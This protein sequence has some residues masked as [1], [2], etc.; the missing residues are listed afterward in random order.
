MKI[1][2]SGLI[3]AIVIPFQTDFSL[4][5]ETMRLYV[6]RISSC[7]IKGL[8][9]NTDAGEGHFLLPEERKK[10][11]VL[12]K[13]IVP[14]KVPVICGLG[15]A[16]TFQAVEMAKEF[17]DLGVDCFLVFPHPAFRG[18]G[19]NKDKVVINY[20]Q[21]I[22]RVGIPLII[23]QLQ[24]E[25]GGTHYG[26]ET[27]AELTKIDEV[28]AIKEASFDALEFKETVSFLNSLRKKIVILT[29]NDNFIPESF[30]LGA[31]GALIGFG[32][33]FTEIQ[34]EVI[35]LLQTKRYNQALALFDKISEICR[36]CF[37]APVRDYRARIKEVLV[38][39]GIFKTSLVR[40][41][42]LPLSKKEREEIRTLIQ[43]NN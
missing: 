41:P 39:Q 32:A 7:G 29:G 40:P 13:E 19:N 38:A 35:N 27:L 28:V 23:F 36:Y 6:Q 1:N 17:K 18:G 2:L 21:Q 4:D 42:L 3:P 11:V 33:I 30:L 20:H 12:A 34:V 14:D 24:E 9:V 43:L 8:A 22:A 15:G 10:I 25:L 16:T 37:R 26:L 5:E 31:N